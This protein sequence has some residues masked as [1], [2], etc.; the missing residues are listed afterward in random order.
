M[1]AWAPLLAADIT[2]YLKVIFAI[3]AITIMAINHLLAGL[4]KARKPLPPASGMPA[5]GAA[6]STPRPSPE[7]NAE[8]SAS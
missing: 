4:K 7:L 8:R 2:P 6:G 1:I 3:V 5:R